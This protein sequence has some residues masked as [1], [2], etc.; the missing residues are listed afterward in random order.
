MSSK[1]LAV[2]LSSRTIKLLLRVLWEQVCFCRLDRLH[3]L[4]GNRGAGIGQNFRGV[5]S[6]PGST[7]PS[8]AWGEAS[9]PCPKPPLGFCNEQITLLWKKPFFQNPPGS[10]F[11]ISQKTNQPPK[12]LISPS[13]FGGDGGREAL[14]RPPHLAG[15]VVGCRSLQN[16]EIL[17]WSAKLISIHKG[18]TFPHFL[19]KCFR[20]EQN[21]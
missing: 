11:S 4:V 13:S 5:S 20:D 14:Q 12:Q 16:M 2:R 8:S 17:V 9:I 19:M 10:N 3:L 1:T 18:G 7:G 15:A 6:R 21:T